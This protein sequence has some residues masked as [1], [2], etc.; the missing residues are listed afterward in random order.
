MAALE[1]LN[2]PYLLAMKAIACRDA[3]PGFA[4]DQEDVQFL[5]KKMN[6]KSV[7]EIQE[8]INKYFEDEVL[9]ADNIRVLTKLIQEIHG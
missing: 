6:T 2:Q 8:V 3:L 4:G 1:H 9:G 5:V 7:P